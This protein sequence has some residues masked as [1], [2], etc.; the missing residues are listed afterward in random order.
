[1]LFN[2]TLFTKPISGQKKDKSR[3]TVFLSINITEINKLKL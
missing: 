1:M 3:I 2:Q